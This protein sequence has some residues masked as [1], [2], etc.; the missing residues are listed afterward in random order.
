M[1]ATVKKTFLRE[2]EGGGERDPI[3]F[4]LLHQHVNS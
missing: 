2:R 4:L 3:L 1:N